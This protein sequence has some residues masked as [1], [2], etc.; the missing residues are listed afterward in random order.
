M[1]IFGLAYSDVYGFKDLIENIKFYWSYDI[2]YIHDTKYYQFIIKILNFIKQENIIS[3]NK[4]E[5]IKIEDNLENKKDIS[6]NKEDDFYYFNY[7]NFK[8]NL[9]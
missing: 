9:S 4:N 7:D 2:D 6:E 3:E 1:F 8:Y 5:N